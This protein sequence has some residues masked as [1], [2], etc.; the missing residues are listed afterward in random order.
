MRILCSMFATPL[1]VIG[2]R[3]EVRMFRKSHYGST[4]PIRWL[5]HYS[6]YCALHPSDATAGA[7][8]LA[9]SRTSVWLCCGSLAA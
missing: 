5:T 6:H 4:R 8:P 2:E 3:T 7:Q 1:T 9:S